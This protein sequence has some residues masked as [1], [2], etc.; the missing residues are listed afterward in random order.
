MQSQ[1]SKIS[2][3][4]K[5]LNQPDVGMNLINI[6]KDS[7]EALG[8]DTGCLFLPSE[9][10]RAN[11]KSA[12]GLGEKMKKQITAIKHEGTKSEKR[13]VNE[14][15]KVAAYCRVSTLLEEQEL[16]YESQRDYFKQLIESK[17]NMELVGIYGDQGLS[18]LRAAKRPELQRMLKDVRD[19]KIDL[20]LV[21]SISRLCRNAI[22]MQEIV[23][24]LNELGVVI[25]F[26][27]EGIRS[28]DKQFEL[29]LKF[30]AAIAQE[31]SNSL[32]LAVTWAYRN[33]C[34]R[35]QPTRSCAYGYR[36]KPRK[37]G[38]PHVWEINEAEAEIV[39]MGFD[40]AL[41]GLSLSEIGRRLKSEQKKLPELT[42]KKWHSGTVLRMLK[43]EAYIGDLLTNKV[44]TP[45]YL[46]GR[47]VKNNGEREQFY[48][49]NH[50]PA[51]IS[52][53]VFERVGVILEQKTEHKMEQRAQHK[54]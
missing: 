54:I 8:D 14:I 28:N 17:P 19:G 53:E 18:G 34:K 36:K 41:E 12:D 48:L 6:C 40:L 7:S 27:K 32:S 25:D 13:K 51:I 46:T 16:S 11:G 21:K 44:Y 15:L 39:K 24:E 22:E 43:N 26:E 5:N 42:D 1:T 9:G 2:Q 29:V 10:R 20:I 37:Q 4:H 50:H 3:T 52:R 38:E 30:L 49:E 31:E 33:N 23:E 47:T 35:G 45:D